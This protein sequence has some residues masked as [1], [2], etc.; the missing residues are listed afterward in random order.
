MKDN[1]RYE[2]CRC[3]HTESNHHWKKIV[4]MMGLKLWIRYLS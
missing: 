2:K 4:I 3:G 1:T